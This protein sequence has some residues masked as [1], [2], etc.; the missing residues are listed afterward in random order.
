MQKNNKKIEINNFYKNFLKFKNKKDLRQFFDKFFSQNEIN[1][2]EN[3]FYVSKLL[4]QNIS[5]I[6][7]QKQINI[8]C[9]TI[10]KI[11]KRIKG[12]K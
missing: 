7:I 4:K 1:E 3:R 5:Y 12:K 11:S 2:F 6:K 8:S 10:A 9:R